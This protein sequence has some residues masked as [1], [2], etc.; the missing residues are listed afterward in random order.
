MMRFRDDAA[1]RTKD[2]L[3]LVDVNMK[4]SEDEDQSRECGVR[5]NRLEPVVVDVEEDHLR[6]GCAQDQVSEL[7]HLQGGLE[8]KLQFGTL[9]HDV[10]E[11]E[12]V[13]LKWVQH[14]L[15]RDDD[16]LGL[17]LD[18][19]GTDQ[20]SNFFCGLPFGELGK[21]LLAGPDAG[22]DD[23]QE[24]LT[25]AWVENEDGSVDRLRGQVTLERLVDGD[26]VDVGVVN[27][28]ND[29]IA[30]QL[31]V[32]LG[33][34]VRLRRFTGV[35][36]EPLADSLAQHVKGRIGLH[37]LGQS[38]LHQRLSARNVI[39]KTAVEGV[40]KIEGDQA[41][42]RGR[43]DAHVVR[44]VVQVLGTGVPLN[45]VRI[46]V[47]PSQLNVQPVLVGG[48]AIVIVLGVMK[49]TWLGHRPLV[50]S[51]QDQIGAAAVHLVRLSGVDRLLLHR[52]DL[53]SVQLLIEDLHDVHDNALVDL[54]PQVGSED[55]NQRYLQGWNFSVHKDSRQIELHLEA[56]VHVGA[57]DRRRPPQRET[58]IWNLRQT[59]TL[60]IRELLEL[61]AFFETGCLFPEKPFP[62]WE[63]GALEETVLEDALDSSEGLDHVRSVGIQIPELSVVTLV[64]P[65]EWVHAEDLILLHL[66]ADAPAAIVRKGVT[67]LAEQRV[68]SRNT[69]IPRIFQIF[70]GEASVL[71]VGLLALEG[72]LCP[73][74]LGVDELALP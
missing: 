53:Q 66:S 16:L 49:Q 19:Q 51:E 9:Q 38:L 57:V 43:V 52:L 61:H 56:D 10:G 24:Q 60:G 67:V 73:N 62:S 30:E 41:S 31:S 28:P 23:L 39:S 11:I 71:G 7:F 20:R 34:Q 2:L 47:P 48:A 63:V 27:K 70:Q 50:G 46:E 65:F 14:A 68:D 29:L 4:A 17:L 40:G 45:V 18:W 1:V 44:R 74:A 58:T 37:D 72:V 33:T 22:V 12:R 42:R 35:Q 13:N 5:R 54:L 55:L 15:S 21:A 36:L 32:V 25:R 64:R 59:G 69:T 3:D 6:L 8:R 26:T